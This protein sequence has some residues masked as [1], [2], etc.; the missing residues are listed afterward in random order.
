MIYRVEFLY[1]EALDHGQAESF[2]G[3]VRA[4]LKLAELEGHL[5]WPRLDS[6]AIGLIV[7]GEGDHEE[8]IS[9]IGQ[10][11]HLAEVTPWLDLRVDYLGEP[12]GD[13]EALPAEE[14]SV[15]IVENAVPAPG[16][17]CERCNAVVP[18]HLEWCPWDLGR[19]GRGRED[20]DSGGGKGKWGPEGQELAPEPEL[21]TAIATEDAEEKREREPV[22][23]LA[24]GEMNAQ[25]S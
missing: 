5:I 24:G 3:S 22:N 7:D 6:A 21:V 1:G 8:L 19:H 14:R 15:A 23:A 16:E 9:V 18:P 20:F 13:V 11:L 12:P 4:G 2:V 25:G 10:H 17:T